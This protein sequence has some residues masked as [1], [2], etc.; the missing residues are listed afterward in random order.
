M[1]NVRSRIWL[2]LWGKWTKRASLH[3]MTH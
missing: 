2:W 1:Q 3:P